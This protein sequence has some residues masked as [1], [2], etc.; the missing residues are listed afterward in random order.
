MAILAC[1]LV[2]RVVGELVRHRHPA[3]LDLVERAQ[4]RRL[5]VLSVDQVVPADQV[6]EEMVR[7]T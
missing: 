7:Q 2:T 6:V 5:A 4:L 3:V 1:K